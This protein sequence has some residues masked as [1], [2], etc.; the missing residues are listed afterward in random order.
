MPEI[1]RLQEFLLLIRRCV[2]WTAAEFGEQIGVTRQTI[3][4]LEANKP[5]KYKLSKTQYLAIRKVLDD[6]IKRSPKD[7]NMLEVLLETLVDHPERFSQEDRDLVVRKAKIVTPS[8]LAKSS[9]REEVSADWMNNIAKGS[10]GATIFTLFYQMLAK[11]ADER[12]AGQKDEVN[13][14][15]I[16]KGS[17]APTGEQDGDAQREPVD[18]QHMI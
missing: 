13:A 15:C 16:E 9:T 4:N 6:E 2:G 12:P 18:S 11:K 17:G 7:T 8:I 3:N 14:K 5:D 10:L 1:E